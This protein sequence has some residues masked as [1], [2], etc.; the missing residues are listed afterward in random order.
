MLANQGDDLRRDAAD[1]EAAA[2]RTIDGTARARPLASAAQIFASRTD[3]PFWFF[4]SDSLASRSASAA[5]RA[6]RRWL[7]RARSLA[8]ILLSRVAGLIR[9]AVIA[10]YL[11]A[12]A[13]T[14]AF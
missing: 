11:G 8:G 14:D 1:F 13:A 2:Q 10:R 5:T 12:S 9:N 6:P 4:M 3:E 7:C